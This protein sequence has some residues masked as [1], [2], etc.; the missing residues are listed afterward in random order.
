MNDER[1]VGADPGPMPKA[2]TR[3]RKGLTVE[4]ELLVG[5]WYG[6]Y[7]NSPKLHKIAKAFTLHPILVLASV[8]IAW[9]AGQVVF[10]QGAFVCSNTR[11]QATPYGLLGAR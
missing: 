8:K 5:S 11:F 4:L 10:F 2:A 6:A 7:S 9:E 1:W 3:V